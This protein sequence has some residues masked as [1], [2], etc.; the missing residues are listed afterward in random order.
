MVEMRVFFVRIS[1]FKA[2]CR[3]ITPFI[4]KKINKHL[5]IFLKIFSKLRYAL[6]TCFALNG[7]NFLNNIKVLIIKVILFITLIL[8]VTKILLKALLKAFK[9]NDNI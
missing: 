2:L 4:S 9:L 5:N 7:K 8:F 3:F 6:K 1:S